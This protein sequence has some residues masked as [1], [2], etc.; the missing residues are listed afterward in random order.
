MKKSLLLVLICLSGLVFGQ[1]GMQ[2]SQTTLTLNAKA[3]RTWLNTPNTQAESNAGIGA[4]LTARYVEWLYKSRYTSGHLITDVEGEL[5][6]NALLFG[7]ENGNFA[8][9]TE[10]KVDAFVAYSFQ[11]VE[12]GPGLLFGASGNISGMYDIAGNSETESFLDAYIAPMVGMNVADFKKDGGFV[13]VALT[14]G[15]GYGGMNIQSTEA[16]VWGENSLEKLVVP[17]KAF[18]VVKKPKSSQYMILELTSVTAPVTGQ[19]DGDASGNLTGQTLALDFYYQLSDR[20]AITA[21]LKTINVVNAN[22]VQGQVGV[23]F[24]FRPDK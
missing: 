7:N 19:R 14:F 1:N 24:D 12:S 18:L 23:V 15:V 8:S 2:Q 22:H 21:D 5:G 20:L 3:V 9:P 13:D 11:G 16:P 17:V 6:F 4:T 10:P